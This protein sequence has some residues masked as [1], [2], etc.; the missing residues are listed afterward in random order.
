LCRPVSEQADTAGVKALARQDYESS[1]GTQLGAVAILRRG[2]TRGIYRYDL[3]LYHDQSR[4]FAR[5]ARV[6]LY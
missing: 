5:W 6:P 2:V 1:V 4:R 3:E